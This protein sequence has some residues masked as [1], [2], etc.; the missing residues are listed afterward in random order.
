M[1]TVTFAAMA[2]T[3]INCTLETVWGK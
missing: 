1:T 3:T 2:V